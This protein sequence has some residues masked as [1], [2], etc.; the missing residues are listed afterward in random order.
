MNKWTPN[1][2]IMLCKLDDGKVV[3]YDVCSLDKNGFSSEHFEFIGF[4]KIHSV[5]RRVYTGTA[6]EY[7]W[8]RKTYDNWENK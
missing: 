4:G 2:I 5:N 8:K 3:E 7:F 6:Q 1:E